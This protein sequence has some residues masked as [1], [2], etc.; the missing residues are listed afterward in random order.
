MTNNAKNFDILIT[1][2]N[3]LHN[4]FDTT[5]L[6]SDLYLT[7]VLNT[8]EQKPYFRVTSLYKKFLLGTNTS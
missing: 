5:K 8:S 3:V 1:N 4:Y 2:L 7:K 6:F